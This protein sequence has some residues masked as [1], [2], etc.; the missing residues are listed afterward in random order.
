MEDSSI[1]MFEFTT[2]EESEIKK[3]L[4]QLAEITCILLAEGVKTDGV[5]SVNMFDIIYHILENT[6]KGRGDAMRFAVKGAIENN[7]T[8]EIIGNTKCVSQ[9]SIRF[10]EGLLV[11]QIEFFKENIPEVL[12]IFKSRNLHILDDSKDIGYLPDIKDMKI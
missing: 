9:N 1:K 8:V 4:M 12:T 10:L 11:N 5:P 6:E 7:G 2:Q 3:V